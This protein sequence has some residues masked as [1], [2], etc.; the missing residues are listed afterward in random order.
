MP[1]ATDGANRVTS[2]GARAFTWD[3]ADR[4]VQRGADTF[5]YDSLGRLTGSTIAGLPSFR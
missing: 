3:G 1:H 4:L 2:D 5:A